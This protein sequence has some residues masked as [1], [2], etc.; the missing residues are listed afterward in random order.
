M[1]FHLMFARVTMPP[2]RGACGLGPGLEVQLGHC[3]RAQARRVLNVWLD[4]AIYGL[5]TWPETFET[6][7]RRKLPFNV[8]LCVMI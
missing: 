4:R 3:Q 1:R 8:S 6:F 5:R 7:R 2:L